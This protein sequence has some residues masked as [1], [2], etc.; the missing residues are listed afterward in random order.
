MDI[1]KKKKNS[2]LMSSKNVSI[3]IGLFLFVT[4]IFFAKSTLNKVS[5]AKKDLLFATVKQGDLDVTVEGYGKLTSDKLQL[6][7]TLTRATVQEIILK[8]GAAVSKESII[9]KLANPE[10]LQQVENA[11]QELSQ[12]KANLRQLKVNQ[13]R[14]L[15]DEDSR[16]AELESRFESA[17]LRRTAEEKL[18]KDGIVS[19]LTYK[20]SLLNEK[21][22]NKRIKILLQRMEQLSFVHQEGVNIQQERIKQQQGKLNVAQDRLNKLNVKAG[23]DGV[24][25][26]LSVKLGQSLAPGQEV[27]LIGSV[28]ELIALIRVPQS[29]AQLIAVGQKA[30]VDTRQD[31]IIGKV[32]RIDPIVVD[33]TV[34]IEISLP[35]SLPKSARPQQNIDATITAT[36]LKNVN[37]IER[38]ANTKA[39]S[40]VELYKLNDEQT[41]ASKISLK[42]GEKTGRFIV[43]RSGAQAGNQFI[44]SDLSNYTNQQIAIN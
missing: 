37:Y 7:T 33:N 39:Q 4:L 20:E 31:K 17:K 43:V 3:V 2:R 34:E 10:L 29:Q 27:A 12:V 14:E 24:L 22:L 6:I 25:Q 15:L 16:L 5:I 32:V 19:E 38:P 21:Q 41:Q 28:T 23:F 26:R 11:Q 30:E 8:P 35:P 40:N 42:F 1:V 18:V 44:I 36:T 9:V 13:K